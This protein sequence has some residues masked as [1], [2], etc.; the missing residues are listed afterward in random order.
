M[1]INIST[2]NRILRIP[3]IALAILLAPIALLLG[4]LR[5]PSSNRRKH[6]L[7]DRIK[8]DWIPRK[9]YIYIGYTDNF[10]LGDFIDS[11]IITKPKYRENVIYDIWE[12]DNER[13][14]R[15]E[16]DEKK[17][18]ATLWQ[19]IGGDFDGDPLLIIA[20]CTP[21]RFKIDK[22]EN[23]FHIFTESQN[24][25]HILHNGSSVT[26]AHAEGVVIEIIENTLKQWK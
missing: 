6:T 23:N 21:N 24:K 13:W 12:H 26:I 14:H 17:R 7:E 15:S 18:V 5:I 1:A 8:E 3:L 22:N 19:D 4:L 11:N 10:A 2:N 16:P 9:K 25:S 20:I